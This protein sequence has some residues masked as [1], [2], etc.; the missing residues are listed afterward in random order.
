MWSTKSTNDSK[1]IMQGD[2]KIEWSNLLNESKKIDVNKIKQLTLEKKLVLKGLNK[3]ERHQ[4]YSVMSYS[5]GLMFDKGDN[6]EITIY[7]SEIQIDS[8]EDSSEEETESEEESE[9]DEESYEESDEESYE[10][11]DEESYNDHKKLINKYKKVL[12]RQDETYYK[13]TKLFIYHSATLLF[14]IVYLIA[15]DPIR[16]IDYTNIKK[17]FI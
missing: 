13:L 11:S 12:K 7:T 10:E 5:S 15:A 17:C 4:I 16:T 3:S 8:Q 1:Q 6:K 9:S 14:G 2:K